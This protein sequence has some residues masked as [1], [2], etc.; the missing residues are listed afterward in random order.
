[1][2]GIVLIKN[3]AGAIK[4]TRIVEY[5]HDTRVLDESLGWGLRWVSGR[6]D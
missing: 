5:H 6:K 4:V 1:L 3:D 2:C